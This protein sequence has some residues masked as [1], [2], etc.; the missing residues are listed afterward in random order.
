VKETHR[1]CFSASACMA[2]LAI[3]AGAQFVRPS[4]CI[5]FEVDTRHLAVR[6]AGFRNSAGGHTYKQNKWSQASLA[7]RASWACRAAG[8]GRPGRLA[9]L[10]LP[11]AACCRSSSQ[12][13]RHEEGAGGGICQWASLSAGTRT[14]ISHGL[15]GQDTALQRAGPWRRPLCSPGSVQPL[16]LSPHGRGIACCPGSH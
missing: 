1:P 6:T 2:R 4:V 16:A 9:S 10:P 12:V 8:A 15:F 3:R 13:A 14:G 7:S 11:L 5:Q